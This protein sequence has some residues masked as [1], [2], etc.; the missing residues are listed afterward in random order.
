V[1]AGISSGRTTSFE[2]YDFPDVTGAYILIGV[3]GNT[4]NSWTSISEIDVNGYTPE[5]FV[6][7]IW[8]KENLS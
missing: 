6:D 8:Y 5:S 4:E 2:R 3:R 7:K 1:F